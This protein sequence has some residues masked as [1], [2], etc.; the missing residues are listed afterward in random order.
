RTLGVRAVA[1]RLL[2]TS[3]DYRGCPGTVVLSEGFWNSRY[4]G[5][6]SA[7]GQTLSLQGHPF[8]IVGVADGRFFGLSVGDRPQLFVPLCT[9]KIFLG[10]SSQLDDRSMWTLE[11]TGRPKPG[12]TPA[13]VNARLAALA[14]GIIDATI[15][16]NWPAQSLVNY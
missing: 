2:E 16:P 3:D 12:L 13:Q 7:V 11:I 14:P 9:D 5:D 4:A 6:P 10:A 1:G 15:P 8:Q